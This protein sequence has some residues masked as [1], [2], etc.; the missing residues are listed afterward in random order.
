MTIEA[1]HLH[2]LSCA[3]AKVKQ[4]YTQLTQ[5]EQWL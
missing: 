3:I 2:I 5:I 1:Y 4:N